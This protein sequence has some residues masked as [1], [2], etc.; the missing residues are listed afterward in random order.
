MPG[1]RLTIP[2]VT[3]LCGVDMASCEQV[4]A[5][6]VR[7]KFL[8]RSEDGQYSLSASERS[9]Q[10][11]R[12]TTTPPHAEVARGSMEPPRSLLFSR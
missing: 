11:R 3:R 8:S 9:R 10:A 6:L 2:Q 4:I 1:M 7:G 12:L 5:E